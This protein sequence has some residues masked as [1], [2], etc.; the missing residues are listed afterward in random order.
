MTPRRVCFV[1]ENL[2]AAGTELWLSRMIES[3][4][5]RLVE[6][7]LVL[8]D[9]SQN[10]ARLVASCDCPTLVLGLRTLKSAKLPQAMWRLAR[11]LRQHAVEVVQVHH[12]DPTYLAVPIARICRVPSVVQTKYDAGYWLRGADLRLHRMLRRWIHVTIANCHACRAAAIEQE[13]APASQVVVMDNGIDME[14]LLA[15]DPPSVESIGSH[16]RIGMMANLRP[17]KD[18]HSLVSAALLLDD[19]RNCEFRLAGDGELRREL[20]KR[21]DAAGAGTAIRLLGSVE[22]VHEFW[23]DVE[24]GVLCS[25]SEGLP[26][27]LIEGMAAGR[28]MIATRVGGN[29]EIIEDGVTGVLIDAGDPTAL[30]AAIRRL[31]GHPDETLRM[32]QAAREAVASRFQLEAMFRRFEDFYQRL[33]ATSS[34]LPAPRAA[35]EQ[36]H[37]TA[38]AP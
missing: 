7:T 29:S 2:L 15:L 18:P 22:S 19:L 25:R 9:G 26:H 30:A 27:A 24:I 38:S 23:R 4:D 32:G 10:V 14:N 1:V 11:F 16:P 12:A 33:P 13:R 17:I 8:T 20:Q 28:A 31:V 3:L 21:I 35:L 36:E 5:R 6:P 37:S 34:A